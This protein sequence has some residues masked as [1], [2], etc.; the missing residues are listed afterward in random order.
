MLLSGNAQGVEIQT[1]DGKLI[2]ASSCEALLQA[3]LG[4]HVPISKL[5]FDPRKKLLRL[6][7]PGWQ[8]EYEQ[9]PKLF[10]RHDDL[11]IKIMVTSWKLL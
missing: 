10:L 5:Q 9:Y 3:E 11:R 1:P 7:Q 6:E 2:R 4:W 8:I